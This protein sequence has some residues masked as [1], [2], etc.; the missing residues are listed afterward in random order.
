MYLCMKFCETDC[1]ELVQDIVH[2]DNQEDLGFV[3]TSYITC[4]VSYPNKNKIRKVF[5]MSH[6]MHPSLAS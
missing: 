3:I 4:S 2:C 5:I 1:A 6:S